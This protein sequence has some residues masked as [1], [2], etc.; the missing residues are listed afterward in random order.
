MFAEI[1]QIQDV[2]TSF[3]ENYSSCN[4]ETS[5]KAVVWPY[6]H[7]ARLCRVSSLRVDCFEVFNTIEEFSTLASLPCLVVHS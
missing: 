7:L 5:P 2:V 1:R 3:L 6:F 4:L